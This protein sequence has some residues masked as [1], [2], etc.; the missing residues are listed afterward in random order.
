VKAVMYNRQIAKK[1][2]KIVEKITLTGKWDAHRLQITVNNYKKG[3]VQ[4][5][6]EIQAIYSMKGNMT[7][8]KLKKAIYQAL[9]KS[10]SEVKEILP[11]NY[12]ISYKLPTRIQ[13]LKSMHYPENKVALKHARRRFVYEEF[14]LFQLRMQLLKKLHREATQGNAQHYHPEKLQRFIN[15]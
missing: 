6:A 11:S 4:E 12:L 14:L 10:G 3:T 2:I 13:A 9:K 1:H 15:S 7:Q 5:Q 8:G